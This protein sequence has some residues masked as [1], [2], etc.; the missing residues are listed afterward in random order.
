M[1]VT[2]I[3]NYLGYGVGALSAVFAY[4]NRDRYK[5]LISD[6]Y[7][8]GNTEL[9][10]QVADCRAEIS[11]LEKKNAHLAASTAEKEGTIKV[12]EKANSRLPDFGSLA[13]ELTLLS[14]AIN[15]NHTETMKRMTDLASTMTSL[16]KTVVE[17]VDGQRRS[18]SR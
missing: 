13:K 4:V 1:N 5:T 17:K 8:P 9:R 7:I 11:E 16:T 3:F 18:S 15:N 6:I 2:D 14:G 12:L 10:Q